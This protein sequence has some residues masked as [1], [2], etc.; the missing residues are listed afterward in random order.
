MEKIIINEY[1]SI[2]RA[3]KHTHTMYIFQRAVDTWY[4]EKLHSTKFVL[5]LNLFLLSYFFCTTFALLPSVIIDM[6]VP[7]NTLPLQCAVCCM[8]YFLSMFADEQHLHL[9]HHNHHRRSHH[10][11]RSNTSKVYIQYTRPI[12]NIPTNIYCTNFGYYWNWGE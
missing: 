7:M 10:N 1:D 5:T 8:R 11:L 12:P 2:R 4:S 9:H 3:N 6:F